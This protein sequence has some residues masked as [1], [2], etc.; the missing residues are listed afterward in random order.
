VPR[1]GDRDVAA[2]VRRV[3]AALG[4]GAVLTD[5]DVLE[6]YRRDQA[7]LLEPGRP[8][9]A[10]HPT[11]TAEVVAV[12]EAARGHGVPLVPRGAGTGLSGGA[13]A[14]DGAA[15][16]V[17]TRMDAVLDL[18]VDAQT[19]VVQPGVINAD[20]S[21]RAA[22]VGLWYPPDPASWEISTIGGNL[23]TNAGGLCCVKYGVTRDFVLGLEVVLADGSVVRTGRRT[24]K[25][26]A[27]YDVTSL[28]VG[29]EGTL[30]IITE[31]TVRLLAAPPAPTTLVAS[32]PTLQ[33]AAT[34]ITGI[35]A[36]TTP[37]LLEIVDRTT[38]NA[39]EDARRMDLDRDAAALLV[40][41][42]D[43]PGQQAAAEVEIMEQRCSDAG[44]SLVATT[45]DPVE[46][47]LLLEARRSAYPALER[48]GTTLLDD[49][50]VPRHR[51]T[52]LIAAI[53]RIAAEHA[54]T[55]GTFGHAGDGNLHP[56]FVFDA[57]DAQ[58]TAAVHDAFDAI[59][60]ATLALGGTVTGEH[61]IG[62]LKREHLARELGD[63]QLRLQ[64]S[65]K[66]ALDPDGLLNPG[67]VL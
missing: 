3:C 9:A 11:S 52:D 4:D 33:A 10:L 34:A 7:G 47:E 8:V 29:S 53:E 44:A 61:G 25:G 51:I 21:R 49:V 23:A 57:A 28:F 48:A 6:A 54:V 22:E 24:R 58:Q 30:G 66:A 65:I 64:R 63:T 20:L 39:I 17:L 41:Q 43:L 2:F 38:I 13:N 45:D 56:T 5:P 14:T 19:A 18:D 26:V 60:D 15:V 42:S 16:L 62:M 31:A 27:G 67:K 55:I 59:V 1:I 32:F 35:C 36:A 50:A 37:S 40:A 46:G 12:V